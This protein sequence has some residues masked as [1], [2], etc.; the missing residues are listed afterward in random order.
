MLSVGNTGNSDAL[1]PSI[2]LTFPDTQVNKSR[3]L[4]GFFTDY[5]ARSI[6]FQEILL[7][8]DTGFESTSEQQLAY[9]LVAN[10]LKRADVLMKKTS[11]K[12]VIA[13]AFEGSERFYVA[14]DNIVPLHVGTTIKLH[15]T[16]QATKMPAMRLSHNYNFLLTVRAWDMME[17]LTTQEDF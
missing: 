8:T 3:W 17:L 5:Q 9:A 15:L 16:G 2:G 12:F 11:S 6:E 13:F 1:Q 7:N 4:L 10:G 14:S